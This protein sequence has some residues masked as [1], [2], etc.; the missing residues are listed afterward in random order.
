MFQDYFREEE[1]VRNN[2]LLLKAFPA[3]VDA[4]VWLPT[5]S[6]NPYSIGI[7]RD[8]SLLSSVTWGKLHGFHR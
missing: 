7:I 6:C 3:F 8:W 2:E 4:L 1:N 5:H